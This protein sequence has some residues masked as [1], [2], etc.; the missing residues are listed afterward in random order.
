MIL[1]T[2]INQ[3]HFFTL[4]IFLT[5]DLFRFYLKFLVYEN[6]VSYVKSLKIKVLE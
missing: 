2:I 3:H 6:Y 1:E 4:K 5:K